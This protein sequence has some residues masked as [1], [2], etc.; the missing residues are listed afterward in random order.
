MKRLLSAA[1]ILGAAVAWGQPRLRSNDPVVHGASYSNLIAPGSIF[2]V[3]GTS[4]AGEGVV[5]APALPLTTALGGVSIRFTPVAGGAAIDCLMVYTTRNQIAGL[6]PSSTAPGDYNVTVTY[7]NQ[8]SAPGRARVVARSIGIVSADAS[9]GGQAQAQIFY[10]AADWSLNRFTSGR[11]GNF[12]TA[13]AHPGEA[14]VLWAT[15]L[16]A[17]AASD[18]NGGTSGDRTAAANVRIRIGETDYT[19]AYAGRSSGLPGTDQ[20]NFTLAADVPTGCTV[21]AQITA[22]GTAS[23]VVTLAI[24]PRGQNACTHPFLSADQ[25]RRMSE[26]GNVVLGFFSL[27]R[28]S[29]ST[30]IPGFGTF[31]LTTE[32]IGGSFARYSVGNLAGFGD[33]SADFS[34]FIGRCLVSRFRGGDVP[35]LVQPPVPLDAGN[36][37]R[38]N[39]PNANNLAVERMTPGNLY[40]ATFYQSGFP[41]IPGSGTGTPTIAAG[42][43]TLSGT[44]GA[45]IGAFN[46]TIAVPAPF[47]WTNRDGIND[48]TRAQGVPLT[49]T[50]GVG[51]MFIVG[52]S[53]TRVGGT[54]EDP[55]FD[56]AAFVCFQNANVG[57]FTVPASV[58]NQLP[59]SGD[60]AA[61]TGLGSLGLYLSGPADGGPFTAP[62]TAGGNIDRGQFQ[63]SF[64]STKTVNYR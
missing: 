60:I 15:G 43:Y 46:A 51:T 49:W 35:S 29:T 13:V 58:L 7:N 4:L 44:G 59:V 1:L 40:G 22:D 64:S 20:Y 21:P 28:S 56:G 33:F 18:L 17:D 57:N 47:T 53:A 11:L 63:Y 31:D 54:A 55:V 16:G 52:T 37:L 27:S 23:N 50:A 6:L 34:N 38:L 10:S 14:M 9:G 19:P 3:F 26:G 8:T 2:V 32:G 48:I 39:G 36:P 25:L 61:G 62:L 24:A 12:T 41:G 30:S 45:D 5:L 42:N